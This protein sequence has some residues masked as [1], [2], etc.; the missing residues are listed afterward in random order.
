MA[1]WVCPGLLVNGGRLAA[2]DL[3]FPALPTTRPTY[4][5][6]SGIVAPIG[7]QGFLRPQWHAAM[8][9]VTGVFVVV[10]ETAGLAD[11]ADRLGDTAR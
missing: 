9:A 3:P 7:I 8:L 6:W 1:A 5:V 4:R 10:P 11:T 2:M